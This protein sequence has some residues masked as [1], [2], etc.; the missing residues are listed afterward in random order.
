[1]E[2]IHGRST[3]PG[4]E[5]ATSHDVKLGYYY[6]GLV[7]HSELNPLHVL[8]SFCLENETQ[9]IEVGGVE[10]LHDVGLLQLYPFIKLGIL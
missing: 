6:L 2:L 4:V 7:D 3:T 8:T 10:V 1:M 5:D 9:L